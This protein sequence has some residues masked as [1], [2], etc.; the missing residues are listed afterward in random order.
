LFFIF[1]G[2]G[3][4]T[5]G[6]TLASQT[7]CHLSHS[8]SPT[9][10]FVRSCAVCCLLWFL[11]HA[12]AMVLW[13][14]SG[15][16]LWMY[17]AE[18]W[19]CPITTILPPAWRFCVVGVLGRFRMDSTVPTDMAFVYRCAW[20]QSLKTELTN[21]AYQV[22]MR[23]DLYSNTWHCAFL[24]SR[25]PW[26]VK[27]WE[28]KENAVSVLWLCHALIK[29]Y[30]RAN[31]NF[32]NIYFRDSF[33]FRQEVQPPFMLL[34]E[35]SLCLFFLQFD[36]SVFGDECFSNFPSWN[37]TEVFWSVNCFS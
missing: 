13:E 30:L 8:T 1:G 14:G 36:Y 20:S 18:C 26:R 7:L 33:V 22:G 31:R 12:S 10:C 6:L 11:L 3:L 16:S 35:F 17:I 9:K 25:Y 23:S 15:S 24:T 19:V 29:K 28:R 4:W 37:S 2:T 34:S 32:H 5:W 21:Q 27:I